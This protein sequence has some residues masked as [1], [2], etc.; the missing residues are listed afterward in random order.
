MTNVV[1]TFRDPTGNSAGCAFVVNVIADTRVPVI[2][3]CPTAVSGV[4]PS[5][6]TTGT[7]TWDEPTAADDDNLPVQL[8]RSHFPGSL[9]PIG[10]TTVRYVFMDSAGN[11]AICSFVVTIT[12]AF[13]ATNL[14]RTTP[15]QGEDDMNP[16]TT[17]GDVV[18]YNITSAIVISVLSTLLTILVAAIVI[19][20]VRRRVK[21]LKRSRRHQADNSDRA[22]F[23]AEFHAM[24][25]VGSHPNVVS[26][27]GACRYQDVLYV[28]LEYAP[29]GDLLSYLRS[30]RSAPDGGVM[31]SDQLVK[32]AFD[33]AKGMEHLSKTGLIHRDLAARNILLGEDLVA[34]ISDFGLSREG[35]IYV[36]TSKRPVPV[37]WL[38]IE[39]LVNQS[40][41]TQSDVYALM[42]QCWYE[43]PNRRPSFSDLTQILGRMTDNMSP[44][45]E[46]Q[47]YYVNA[48]TP[49]LDEI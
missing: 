46:G 4:A 30:V 2:T 31:S 39:S 33:V 12:S 47:A 8:A 40:Y 32:F 44:F 26:L 29:N 35:D 15:L 1:Y 25:I 42:T 36:Q 9:F 7:A 28:A 17:T 38:A 20:A 10:G 41:T 23:L 48:I 21:L 45:V 37:R 27:L 49:E 24:T 3:G 5:G 13:G 18:P 43:D 6:S 14:P 11:Q 22:N 16:T 34:K 19:Y